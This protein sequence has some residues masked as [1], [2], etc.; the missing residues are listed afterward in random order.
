MT[1]TPSVVLAALVH[2]NKEHDEETDA[3]YDGKRQEVGVYI[4][5]LIIRD[6]KVHFRIIWVG[7]PI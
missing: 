3:N 2:Y 1:S 4:E 6:K 5:R 7:K